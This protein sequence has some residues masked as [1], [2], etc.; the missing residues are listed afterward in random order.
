[1]VICALL[2]LVIATGLY[3]IITR[4][5]DHHSTSANLAALKLKE[6]KKKDEK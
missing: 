2:S 5:V 4:M 1:M 6:E 3:K